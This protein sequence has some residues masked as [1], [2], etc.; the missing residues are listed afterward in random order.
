MAFFESRPTHFRFAHAKPLH[1][2]MRTAAGAPTAGLTA[3]LDVRITKKRTATAQIVT[4]GVGR[5]ITDRGRGLYELNWTAGDMNTD[6]PF[7]VE[8]TDT[9]VTAEGL[10]IFFKIDPIGRAGGAG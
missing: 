5:T 10:F 3:T 9:S 2:V 7:T 4:A 1:F 8:V 6:G